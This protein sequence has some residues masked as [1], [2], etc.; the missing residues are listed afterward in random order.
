VVVV[1][2]T[3]GEEEE[4][5]HLCGSGRVQYQKASFQVMQSFSCDVNIRKWSLKSREKATDSIALED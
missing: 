1:V 2:W 4:E 5:K 3:C